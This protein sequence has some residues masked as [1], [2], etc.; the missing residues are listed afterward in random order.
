MTR[1]NLDI[2]SDTYKNLKKIAEQ[3]RTTV[4]DLLRRATKLFLFVRSI[5]QDPNARL[6]VE[7]EGEYQEI[8]VDL[9]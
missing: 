7:R 4:A 9:I 3:E 8:I 5:K 2:P 6:V 1:Y